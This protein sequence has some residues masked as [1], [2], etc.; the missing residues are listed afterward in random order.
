MPVSLTAT[1]KESL[2]A[3]IYFG[4]CFAVHL[5][6]YL[7]TL[8]PTVYAGDAGQFIAIVRTMGIAHPPGHPTYI[9]I[10]KLFDMI[11]F[12]NP[13]FGLNFMSAFFGAA[14]V[15]VVFLVIRRIIHHSPHRDL[16]AFMSAIFFGTSGAF[17]G[18]ALFAETYTL[19]MFFVAVLTLLILRIKEDRTKKVYSLVAIFGL[20]A[21]L[22]AGNHPALVFWIPTF[23]LIM[24]IFRRDLV[25]SFKVVRNVVIS[26]AAGFSVYFYVYFRGMANPQFDIPRITSFQKF[27]YTLLAKQY[28]NVPMEKTPLSIKSV[29]SGV[30]D[31]I[32]WGGSDFTV[33]VWIITL[34]AGIVAF[35]K[36]YKILVP[37][38]IPVIMV[39]AASVVNPAARFSLD[40]SSYG[41]GAFFVF[42]LWIG[43]GL[44][45]IS[46]KVNLIQIR[47]VR[48]FLSTVV[49]LAVVCAA[50]G[51][52]RANY[53]YADKS[54]EYL[55]YD[56]GVAVLDTMEKDAVLF[57]QKD[58]ISFSL[59]YL[60]AVE[61]M[62]PD[63][64]IYNRTS[65]MF[66]NLPDL[67]TVKFRSIYEVMQRANMLED[68]FIK[69]TDRPVYFDDRKSVAKLPGYKIYNKGFLYKISKE[70]ED[71]RVSPFD[72]YYIRNL[73]DQPDL[74]NM[75]EC[76]I[77]IDYYVHLAEDRFSV[78][79]KEEALAA[80]D[81]AKFYASETFSEKQNIMLV[82]VENG[83]YQ[84]AL[85]LLEEQTR[86]L[87]GYAAT[88]KKIGLL[89]AK[90]IKNSEM[91]VRYLKIYLEKAPYAFDRQTVVNL[92]K[93]VSAKK[94][95]P[96]VRKNRSG[97]IPV[98]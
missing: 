59:A 14:G 9:L 66:P 19:N 57:I 89:Y 11:P 91:A 72:E 34:I 78:G 6:L 84:E 58:W 2:S 44:A 38:L 54:T 42:T 45:V 88:Y 95:S 12:V 92:I 86:L 96:N 7:M 70:K 68:E 69:S 17:W 64:T 21:G 29:L 75:A 83:Y 62:R 43:A 46:K 25:F 18:Y 32:S 27:L 4:L 8:C 52:V 13:S 36:Y 71:M 74:N 53:E 90:Y 55:D 30:L 77:F 80:L 39:I 40:R 35:R 76:K 87:P 28:G 73:Y 98:K 79:R 10:G 48:Y 5:A 82:Y 41:I 23:V 63:V 31:A 60:T 15:A 33:A 93:Q 94:T 16:I 61:K 97:A 50:A 51:Q 1:P 37:F 85:A 67:F 81:M 22:G 20:L 24:L 26:A 56:A 49:V 3:K 47:Q 65:T